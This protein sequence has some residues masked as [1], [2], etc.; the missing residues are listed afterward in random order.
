MRLGMRDLG[1]RDH[2]T[3]L[4]AFAVLFF[5][6]V[7]GCPGIS[8]LAPGASKKP[9]LRKLVNRR[10][11]PVAA[12]LVHGIAV[13]NDAVRVP[14]SSRLRKVERVFRIRQE[15]HLYGGGARRVKR[16]EILVDGEK[17]YRMGDPDLDWNGEL[18]DL[19]RIRPM[20]QSV[21]TKDSAFNW[22][23]FGRFVVNEARR[24]FPGAQE[25]RIH[26]VFRPWDAAPEDEHVVHGRVA[27]AP[28]WQLV[29]LEEDEL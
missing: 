28:D 10:A 16:L 17:V 12:D 7:M 9:G 13:V 14:F 19:R 2:L 8:E 15:W 27:R 18:F 4:G 23:G 5:L 25:V 20:A 1:I 3:G 21:T 29:E 24:D 26:G 22:K 6:V 11:G